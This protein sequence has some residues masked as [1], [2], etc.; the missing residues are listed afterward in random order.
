MLKITL[1]KSPIGYS[2]RQKLTAK[3]LGLTKM[4][5]SAVKP[6]NPQTRGMVKRI[7]H[8]VEVEQMH[9]AEPGGNESEA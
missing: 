7:S 6:D 5:S 4:N 9:K 3:A 8:L 2:E 1:R